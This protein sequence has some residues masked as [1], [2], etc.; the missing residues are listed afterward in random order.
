MNF[1]KIHPADRWIHE[2]GESP[3]CSFGNPNGALGCNH[4]H[5]G[6]V[7]FPQ[8]AVI[9]AHTDAGMRKGEIFYD[10]KG[11]KILK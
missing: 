10:I 7:P 3:F 5:M 4:V 1:V 9:R 8:A 11:A 2:A 6:L